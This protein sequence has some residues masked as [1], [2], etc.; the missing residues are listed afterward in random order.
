[1]H[2]VEWL[3]SQRKTGIVME[4]LG[5]GLLDNTFLVHDDNGILFSSAC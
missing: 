4:I 2:I 3:S 1:M 5:I